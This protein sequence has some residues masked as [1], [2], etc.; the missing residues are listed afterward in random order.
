MKN[1]E[2]IGIRNKFPQREPYRASG[3]GTLRWNGASPISGKASR[4]PC[5]YV[6][7]LPYTLNNVE[8][9]SCGHAKR[10]YARVRGFF[11]LENEYGRFA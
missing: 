9:R 2:H 8:K 6:P 1:Q 7:T 3:G 5:S 11:G 10:P 4:L